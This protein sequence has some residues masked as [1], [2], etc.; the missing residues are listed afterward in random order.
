[1]LWAW[2]AQK[3]A[4][5]TVRYGDDL[6]LAG[7]DLPRPQRVSV[8]TRHGPVRGYLYRVPERAGLTPVVLHAHGGAWVMRH[9]AMDDFF[10]RYLVATAGVAVLNLDY[11]VA[12]QVRHPVASEQVHDA[13]A[14]VSAQGRG[15]GLDPD[16]MAISGFSAGGNLAAAAMLLGRETG[17][18]S[19]RLAL[20]GVPALDLTTGYA[21]KAAALPG[22]V[23]SML[24]PQVLDMVRG[25]Y[26]CDATRRS[27]PGASPLLAP[28]LSGLPPTH[29]VTAEHDL[30]RPEGERF[31]GRLREVGNEVTHRRVPGK[32]H[33][34]MLGTDVEGAR[35]E[36]DRL[37][38]VVRD[39]LHA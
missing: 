23:R 19:A 30:L 8:P 10:C 36:L 15:L 28:D 25:T 2:V 18:F 26:F 17:A 39:R 6:Q 33:Y 37:A 3:S 7:T 38:G 29:V 32:D 27:E 31:V 20:L 22:R 1:M 9:P 14:H 24:G 21:E 35:S 12:P 16:R 34:F 5:F 4:R 11:D 13:A